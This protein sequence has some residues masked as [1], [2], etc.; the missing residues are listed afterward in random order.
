M[1][2]FLALFDLAKRTP[3]IPE[4][5]G[6]IVSTGGDDGRPSTRVVLLK[7]VDEEGLVFYTNLESR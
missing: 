6:M 4:P 5:T 2:R 7:S 1:A 3:Q